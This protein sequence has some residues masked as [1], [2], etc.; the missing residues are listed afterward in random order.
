MTRRIASWG[1]YDCNGSC[2][3]MAGNTV[4]ALAARDIG[5]EAGEQQEF[6]DRARSLFQRVK[7][8]A[9]ATEAL[10]TMP[11]DLVASLKDC[12]LFWML[13]PS[14]LGGGG[15]DL[16]AAMEVI[17]ELS[18][19]DGSTGWTFM[20]N[21]TNT[22]IAAAFCGDAA[23]EAMF[24]G[25]DRAITAGMFGPG[26]SAVEVPGG[27]QGGGR[28]GFG[29]GC[30]HASWVCGGLIIRQE[31]GT[32]QQLANG[33]PEVRV[34]FVPRER[35]SFLGNWHVIGMAGTGSYDF[36]IADQFIGADF[37][38]ERTSVT[39]VRGGSVF[40][41]GPAAFACAG[42]AAVALGLMKQALHEIAVVTSS[43]K[44]PM[45]PSVVADHPAFLH[46]F[47]LQEAAYRG[48]RAYLFSVF[49]DAQRTAAAGERVTDEQRAR[50]RQATTWVHAVAADVVR[51]CHMWAGSEAIRATSRLGRCLR[52]MYVATQHAF[53]DPVTLV[54]A[55]PVILAS[56]LDDGGDG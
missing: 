41:L 29:S 1:D 24:G 33:S 31:D 6:L 2:D 20:A 4:Q 9:K 13:V 39:P 56:W 44:R 27:F 38:L 35:A 55:G 7:D 17:E 32:P 5:G 16:L 22:A 50:F 46:E 43:K 34:C 12:E 48:A 53:V 37:T 23:V 25:K 14:D 11:P 49:A 47:G 36:L 42:H 3:L 52:D 28:F 45:Y 21:S 51:R 54:D 19:A 8:R 18:Y 15:A 40:Q 30:G 26:G 10:G